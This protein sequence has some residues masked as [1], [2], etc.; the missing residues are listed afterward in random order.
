[1]QP[2]GGWYTWERGNLE[3][4]V[5]EDAVWAWGDAA[6]VIDEAS[7]LRRIRTLASTIEGI[8][9]GSPISSFHGENGV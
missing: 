4:R 5:A 6:K 2:R 1:M 9:S 3:V 7:F 8:D